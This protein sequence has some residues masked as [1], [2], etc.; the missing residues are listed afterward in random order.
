MTPPKYIP[1]F[2]D[3]LHVRRKTI[4]TYSTKFNFESTNFELF[5][6]GGQRDERKKWQKN[7]QEASAVFY[8]VSL[9]EYDQKCYEDNITNRMLESLELLETT[10]NNTFFRDK[11]I[12]L[13]LNKF[14]LYSEKIKKSDLSMV[15]PEYEG[16]PDI[17][18]GVDEIVSRY[19]SCNKG[20]SKRV[21]KNII[22]AT[23]KEDVQIVMTDVIKFLDH[24]KKDL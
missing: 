15:F 12:I 2:E 18:K 3:M 22:T 21:F 24:V 4:G 11:F 14:D 6:V 10:V 13:F 23:S 7:F 17:K 9:S 8:V 19:D 1:S 5:D 16:G 20:D